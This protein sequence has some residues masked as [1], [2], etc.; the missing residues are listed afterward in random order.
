MSLAYRGT[1][2]EPLLV[3]REQFGKVDS[4]ATP[5]LLLRVLRT[6]P[7]KFGTLLLVNA[8]LPTGN[9]K[10]IIWGPDPNMIITAAEDK[11]IR[12]WDIRMET[13]I[14]TYNIEGIFG[15]CELSYM[16]RARSANSSILSVGAGKNAYFFPGNSPG[17]LMSMIKTPHEIA[18]LAANYDENIFVTGGTGDTWVRIYSFDEGKELNI[19]KGHHGPVWTTQFSPDGK[20]CATGSEDG[21]IKLWK[22]GKEPYGLWK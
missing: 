3:T 4:L 18:S 13:P 8:S 14:A 21:T 7:R 17:Q 9:I 6:L 20:L 1:G 10:S 11:A 15:S 12:W 5:P 22:F 2:L 16:P 19:Y